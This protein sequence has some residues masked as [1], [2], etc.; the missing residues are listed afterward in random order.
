MCVLFDTKPDFTSAQHR[1]MRSSAALPRRLLHYDREKVPKGAASRLRRF[2]D[3]SE[4]AEGEV[5]ASALR[6]WVL[7]VLAYDQVGPRE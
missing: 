5:L 6:E 3:S 4:P 2:A 7:A 1:I